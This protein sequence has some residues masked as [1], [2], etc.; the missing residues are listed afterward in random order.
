[1]KPQIFGSTEV[2]KLVEIDRLPLEASWLF[3]QIAPGVVDE[4]REWLGPNLVEPGSQRL[5]MSFHSFVI[6]TPSLNILV[7]TCNGNHKQRPSMPAWN[8][9]DLPYLKRLAA[10]GLQPDDI[11][12]VMC[13][14]LH[15][16]HVGW[17][18][19]LDNGRWVPTFPRARY[20]MS[21]TEY[22]H[23]ESLHRA[24]P[25]Q[26]VNRGSFA[27]S[28]L[29]VVEHEQALL[30]DAG[31]A[32]DERLTNQLSLESAPGH[33]PAGLNLFLNSGGRRACFCGDVIHHAI[34]CSV[35][36]LTNLADHNP[37]QGIET[38][39]NLLER[40]ADSDMLL[41]TGHFPDPT[42]GRV[43]RHGDVYRFRFEE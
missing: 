31:E 25:A 43:V 21:R 2:H 12:I 34:Q 22:N 8:D 39:R 32:I 10:I 42:V 36:E 6:R 33:S 20:V 30:L 14:H 28:V 5:Y 4:Y 7:D 38:R 41:M 23:Y 37:Q 1:M 11:D 3:P 19:R 13:T 27:D 26:P 9:L 15:A 24:G 35:P 18:T 29:P 40:C 17:N 16:D